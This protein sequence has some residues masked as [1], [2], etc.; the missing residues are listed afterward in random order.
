M[1]GAWL[2]PL[3]VRRDR[4]VG[5]PGSGRAVARRGTPRDR[6]LERSPNALCPGLTRSPRRTFLESRPKRAGPR[7]EGEERPTRHRKGGAVISE[8]ERAGSGGGGRN[9]DTSAPSG[10]SKTKEGSRVEGRQDPGQKEETP[11]GSESRTA[12][13]RTGGRTGSKGSTGR[14]AQPLDTVRSTSH[15]PVLRATARRARGARPLS[16]L[17]FPPSAH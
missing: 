12:R 7:L 6:G 1:P 5:A 16:E 13:L 17:P 9:E 4:R 8:D 3:F 11:E 15:A 10:R 2:R 14:N